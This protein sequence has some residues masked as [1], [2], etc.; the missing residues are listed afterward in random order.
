MTDKP[1]SHEQPQKPDPLTPALSD[2]VR[3]VCDYVAAQLDGPD[4]K[5]VPHE[6]YELER[7]T[8]TIPKAVAELAAYFAVRQQEHRNDVSPLWQDY[9][10]GRAEAAAEVFR[11]RDEYLVW[12]LYEDAIAARARLVERP[13]EILLPAHKPDSPDE[14]EIPF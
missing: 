13:G 11:L 14:D 2:E 1:T 12:K 7:V 3:G 5:G 6:D 9:R 4:G 8:L 10:Q